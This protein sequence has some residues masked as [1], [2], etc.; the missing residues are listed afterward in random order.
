MLLLGAMPL[1]SG[2]GKP[3]SLLATAPEQLVYPAQTLICGAV[4]LYF[5][6][7]YEFG[8]VKKMLF[9]LAIAILVLA[10]WIAPQ[11]VFHAEARRY[12]FNPTI[13]AGNYPLFFSVLMLRFLRLTIVVPLL[14][15]IFW[16]GF[17]LRD[18]ID[19]DFEKV[20]FGTYSRFP[21]LAVTLLFALAHWGSKTW[22]PGPDVVPAIFA[23]ALFNL[24]AY[25]TRSLGSCVVAHAATNLLL[26]I[27]ILQTRQWGFW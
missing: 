10:I 14:E 7:R 18:F 11:V 8:S 1:V 25:R 26:G 15:E 24:V 13:F 12:G 20:P 4:L 9:T 5:W 21:F 3:G 6:R 23:G 2:L 22:P 17:L 16:R 19:R 27:Y